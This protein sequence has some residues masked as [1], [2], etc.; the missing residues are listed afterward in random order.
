MLLEFHYV[1]ESSNTFEKNIFVLYA[2]LDIFLFVQHK[3][4]SLLSF[5]A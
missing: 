1:V 2:H 5:Q 4:N 3:I